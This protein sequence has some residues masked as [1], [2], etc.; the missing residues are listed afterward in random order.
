MKA[1][2]FCKGCSAERPVE[3]FSPSKR[4]RAGQSCRACN[5]AKERERYRTDPEFRDRSNRRLREWG[6]KNG[7]KIRASQRK[8]YEKN[9]QKM[10]AA[11]MRWKHENREKNLDITRMWH[12]KNPVRS[13]AHTRMRTLRIRGQTPPDANFDAIA[14]LYEE[15][16]RLTRETGIRHHV[17][18]IVPLSRGGLHHQDNLRVVTITENL[19]KGARILSEVRA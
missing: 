11:S 18:H 19:R 6:E 12:K 14:A 5:A 13:Y 16:A 15:S 2:Q 17:D 9:K 3:L 10:F 8:H 7:D 1:A 4:G